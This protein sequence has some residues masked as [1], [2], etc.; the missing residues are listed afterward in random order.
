M[1]SIYVQKLNSIHA[2][3]FP[4]AVVWKD[5]DKDEDSK[6]REQQSVKV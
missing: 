1:N 6:L 5:A 2:K 3:N 4:I